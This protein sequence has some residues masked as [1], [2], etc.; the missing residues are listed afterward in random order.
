[1]DSHEFWFQVKDLERKGMRRG[2]AVYNVA[3]EMDEIACD[4]AVD[5]VGDPFN[6]ETKVIAFVA[7]LNFDK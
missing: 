7:E 3:F 5:K 2:Q 4:D 6:D 1:M